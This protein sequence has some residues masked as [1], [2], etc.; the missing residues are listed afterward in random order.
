MI[1]FSLKAVKW[2]EIIV[3]LG[4]DTITIEDSVKLSL[5]KLSSAVLKVNNRFYKTNVG[6]MSGNLSQ[7][8]LTN[9]L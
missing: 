6:Y 8:V 7:Y 4:I 9:V 1:F 2:I 3:S 5:Q